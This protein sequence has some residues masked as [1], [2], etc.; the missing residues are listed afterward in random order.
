MGI[1]E[2]NAENQQPIQNKFNIDEWAPKAI[3]E[4]TKK[5]TKKKR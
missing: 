2:E 4:E 3:E 1:K 5:D